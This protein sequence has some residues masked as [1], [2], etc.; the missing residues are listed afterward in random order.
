MKYTLFLF[1]MVILTNC[2][3]RSAQAV[4]VGD[5]YY[6]D[7]TFDRT[8]RDDKVPVTTMMEPLIE[9]YAMIKFRLGWFIGFL[10]VVTMDIYFH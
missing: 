8:V 5:I 1:I 4:E 3:H 10:A 2:W 9:P 6:H 7:G